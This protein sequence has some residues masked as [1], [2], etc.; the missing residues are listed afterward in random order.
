VDGD[1]ITMYYGA[2][3]EVICGAKFSIQEILETLH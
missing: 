1:E 3:D 2:A